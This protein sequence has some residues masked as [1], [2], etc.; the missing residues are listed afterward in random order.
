MMIDTLWQRGR[1]L[2]RR[3]EWRSPVL[4]GTTVLSLGLLLAGLIRGWQELMRYAWRFD[5]VPLVLSSLIYSVALVLAMSAWSVLMRSLR[6]NATWRQNAKF[7]LYSWMARRLPTPAPY[8][9]SRVLLY[10][11]IGVPKRLTGVGLIWENV[12]LIAASALL[13]VL[14]VPLTSHVNDQFSQVGVMLAVAVSMLF[15]VRPAL[16]TWLVNRVLRRFGKAPIEVGLRP[17]TTAF[18]LAIYAGVWLTG[19]LIL[20]CLIR[21]MYP[22]EWTMLPFVVQCWALSGLVSY[23]AFFAPVSF[24]VREATLSYLLSLAIPLSVAIVV[25]LLMR[26][27]NMVNELFWAFIVYRL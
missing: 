2:W 16:L 20:F 23:I 18:T 4:I 25:V 13:I 3:R 15:V 10:E 11:E 7:Y 26:I 12:L 24:G 8:L 5:W 1:A 14:M 21:T 17:S 19:G 27:W 9:T 6:V 22:I